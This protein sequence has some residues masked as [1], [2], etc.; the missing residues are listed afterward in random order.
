MDEKG[1]QMTHLLKKKNS[2]KR[3]DM[4]EIT[5]VQTSSNRTIRQASL[6][7][8]CFWRR[9]MGARRT[10]GFHVRPS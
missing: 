4:K 5:P 8:G 1:D 2:N 9:N 3:L 6:V 10:A 7:L